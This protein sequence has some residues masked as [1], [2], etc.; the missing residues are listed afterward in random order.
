MDSL[1]GLYGIDNILLGQDV[2]PSN[3]ENF[4]KVGDKL[5][6]YNIN[7]WTNLSKRT[8]PLKDDIKILTEYPNLI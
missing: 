1:F 4:E 3:I 7:T 5:W 6:A 8:I 2:I